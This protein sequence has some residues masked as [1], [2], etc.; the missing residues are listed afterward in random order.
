MGHWQKGRAQ[1]PAV[2]PRSPVARCLQFVQ[3]SPSALRARRSHTRLLRPSAEAREERRARQVRPAELL[4]RIPLHRD[5]E[6]EEKGGQEEG[7]GRDGQA[8]VTIPPCGHVAGAYARTDVERGVHHAP[9]GI[10]LLG[11][12]RLS[13]EINPAELES[14]A[15]RGINVLRTLP[16]QGTVIW[17]ART[18]SEDPDWQYV[19]V[20]RLSIFIEQSIV[21]G[22]QWAVFDPNSAAASVAVTRTIEHF[23]WGLWKAGA[24][25]GERAEDAFFVRCDRTTMT[26]A[27]IDSGTVVVIV[28]VAPIRPAEF[29]VFRI[30]GVASNSAAARA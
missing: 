18:T 7:P 16:L 21:R 17:S 6:D 5:E 13:D 20:R 3:R 29:V 23:L 1:A 30:S 2:E 24:L 28:G 12:E 14:L 27:D 25:A 15:A 8:S 19:N 4:V 9:A 22:V 26:Q 10:R 11:V